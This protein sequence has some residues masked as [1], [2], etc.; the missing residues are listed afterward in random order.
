MADSESILKVM[1]KEHGVRLSSIIAATG[2]SQT[3]YL[4]READPSS[5]SIA[6]AAAIASLYPPSARAELAAWASGVIS[7]GRD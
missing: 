4:R 1:R 3:T 6:E 5:V 7:G 2:L